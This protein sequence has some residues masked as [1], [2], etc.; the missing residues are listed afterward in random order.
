[1]A[2][3]IGARIMNSRLVKGVIS[4]LQSLKGSPEIAE[5]GM[6]GSEGVAEEIRKRRYTTSQ[7]AKLDVVDF[8]GVGGGTPGSEHLHH[9]TSVDGIVQGLGGRHTLNRQQRKLVDQ[10]KQATGEGKPRTGDT[11]HGGL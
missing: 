9:E 2:E 3:G 6:P 11:G 1:M 4:A 10:V 5:A 7:Q 8:S